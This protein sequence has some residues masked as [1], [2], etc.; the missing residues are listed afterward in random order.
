MLG[1]ETEYILHYQRSR[2]RSVACELQSPGQIT[3]TESSDERARGN[4]GLV[5]EKEKRRCGTEGDVPISSPLQHGIRWVSRSNHLYSTFELTNNWY[6][7]YRR[8]EVHKHDT[9]KQRIA[10]KCNSAFKV[11]I[12]VIR[13]KWN[14]MAL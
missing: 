10:D 8:I 12:R 9:A 14:I 5:A 13:V 6:T 4:R 7:I 2:V 11:H 3:A 1:R